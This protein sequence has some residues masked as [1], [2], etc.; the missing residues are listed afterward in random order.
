M[1][2]DLDRR[3]AILTYR[4]NRISFPSEGTVS[5]VFEEHEEWVVHLRK[6]VGSCYVERRRGY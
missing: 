1:E 2:E 6:Q 3:F 5:L 4:I